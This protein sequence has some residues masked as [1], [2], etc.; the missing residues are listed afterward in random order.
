MQLVGCAMCGVV[1]PMRGSTTSAGN[2]H[3]MRTRIPWMSETESG[4]ELS[5]C[6][7]CLVRLAAECTDQAEIILIFR[8][9]S[10][11]MMLLQSQNMHSIT[12]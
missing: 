9:S 3:S 11:Y 7:R 6:V 8:S 1:L 12:F 10:K 5:E 4:F 2:S